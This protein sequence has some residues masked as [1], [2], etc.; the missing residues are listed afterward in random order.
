M[1]NIIIKDNLS[2]LACLLLFM[3]LLQNTVHALGL[4]VA[5]ILIELNTQQPAAQMWLSNTSDQPLQAQVR[6]Y[7][8]QQTD[9]NDILTPT[10]DLVAS[11]PMLHIPS[12]TT[13]LVR[14]IKI[15]EKANTPSL[16]EQSYRMIINEI[17]RRSSKQ[18]KFI[19]FAAQYSVPV[20][21]YDESQAQLSPDLS[22]SIIQNGQQAVLKVSNKGT[23]H[24]K[25]S[26]VSLTDH[27]GKT[28]VITPGLLGYVLPNNTM[29]WNMPSFD[30]PLNQNL[31]LTLNIND[32]QLSRPI[33]TTAQAHDPLQ[34]TQ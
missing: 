29:T 19:D 10:Q 33:N 12:K 20:F 1:R 30:E 6:L 21:F 31:I 13:S 22:F 17:P 16:S 18:T 26:A 3:A 7:H 11:P 15:S 2:Y 9:G 4:Q 32:K 28:T 34:S 23:M 27:K 24:A 8:W 25:L 5:P 14:I